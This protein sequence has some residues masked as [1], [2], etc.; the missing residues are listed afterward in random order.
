MQDWDDEAEEDEAITEEVE[1]IRVQ[2][3]IERLCQEHQ[4]IM[5]R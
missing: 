5:R 2:Q 3:E 1:L 4:S